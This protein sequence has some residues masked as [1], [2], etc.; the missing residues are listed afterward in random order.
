MTDPSRARFKGNRK[1]RETLTQ[2]KRHQNSIFYL[3]MV[4]NSAVLRDSDSQ[5]C[6]RLHVHLQVDTTKRCIS[7]VQ[8]QRREVYK[9]LLTAEGEMFQIIWQNWKFKFWVHF[10][11]SAQPHPCK[12]EERTSVVQYDPLIWNCDVRVRRMG[13]L[14]SAIKNRLHPSLCP[15][16]C[17]YWFFTSPMDQELIQISLQVSSKGQSLNPLVGFWSSFLTQYYVKTSRKNHVHKLIIIFD[18]QQHPL[19]AA[20]GFIGKKLRPVI[21]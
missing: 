3:Q 10:L 15:S 18:V 1:Q 9:R 11:P 12:P 8:N 5:V 21:E 17:H 16:K 6:P 13:Y 4:L 14:R 19:S 2:R 20:V 7:Q